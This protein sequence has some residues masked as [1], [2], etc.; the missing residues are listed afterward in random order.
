MTSATLEDLGWAEPFKSAF[1]AR[2]VKGEL[3]A[4]VVEELRGAYV[5][6]SAT[7]EWVASISGRMRHSAKRRIDFQAVGDWVAIKVR[8]EEKK[9]TLQAILPRKSKLSRKASGHESDEQLIA[10][11]LDTVFV[12]TSLNKDFN[13]RRLERYLAM[14]SESG[15][16]AESIHSLVKRSWP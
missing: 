7:A 3:P 8:P 15:A 12:V 10:A 11:N 14:V 6:Q 16:P 5:V 2:A 13:S 9:A 4:R 1:E